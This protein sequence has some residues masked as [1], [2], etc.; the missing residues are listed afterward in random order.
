[1]I[2]LPALF[3]TFFL[4]L[5]FFLSEPSSA[6]AQ[7]A[8]LTRMAPL[9]QKYCVECHG[10][11]KAEAGIALDSYENQADAVEDGETW[12]KVLDA[13]EARAMPPID[14]PQP[15]LD[16]LESIVQ[17]I[18]KDY[19]AAQ[20][21]KRSGTAPVVIRRLNRQEYDNTLRDLTGLDLKLAESFPMDEIGF[22]FDNVGSALNISPV[23]I[24]KYL[25]AAEQALDAA[26]SAPDAEPMA[27]IELIGLNT[28]PLRR[29]EPVT[30]A[31]TLK[32]GEYIVDFSLVRVGISE[33]APTPRLIVSFGSDTRAIEALRVQ[34]ET[35]VYR[36]WM[37][38]GQGDKQVKVE[39]PEQAKL[40]VANAPGVEIADNVSGDQRYGSDRGLHVDSM[41]VKG[42]VVRDFASLPESH[43]RLL[44]KKPGFGDAAR[45]GQGQEV[46]RRFMDRAFR[47]PATDEEIKRVMAIF[48]TANDHGESYEKAVQIALTSV[49]VSPQFLYLVEP[50]TD[51][52]NE[53]LDEFELASRL[54]YFLWS[55]MP[56]EALFSEARAGTLRK[57]LRTQ[58]DR[59]ID[60]PKSIAL[61]ENFTGQWL[62]LRKLTGVSPDPDLFA[63]FDDELKSAMRGETEQ[64][65]AHILKNNRNVLDLIDSD[66]TF[67]NEPLARHYGIEGVNGKEFRQV[68]LADRRRGGVLTQGSVLTLTSN[69]N[70]T[71]P[72]KRG[73]WILQ[74]ILGTPPPPPPPEVEKLDESPQS[75]AAASLRD[76][77]EAHRSAAACASCHKQ[78]DP[79]GFALENYDPVGRWRASDG[80]FPV[81]PSGELA[82]G[83][84]FGEIGELKQIL[85][86]KA[87][88]KFSRCLIEYMLTY[89]LGRGLEPFD[90]CT[91]E[92]V[93]NRLESDEFRIRNIVYGIV[94]SDAFQYRGVSEQGGR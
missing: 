20:C 75:A 14:K 39:L 7:D 30:F 73:Q 57:N 1:V 35:V 65:F 92:E 8:F 90:Y 88:K 85:K 24:E 58:V 25:D 43:R 28:Y 37:S 31:H 55:S 86:T 91:I 5:A 64:F 45:F 50:G 33:T 34:D 44:G 77:L 10:E 89:A 18:E 40:P 21:E 82:G 87:S 11:N 2:K 12:M 71:S 19:L 29:G 4:A 61:V 22:G 78:M 52:K 42:P 93:R 9:F 36:F 41:V 13:I 67:L 66:Y 53:R 16:E 94:E 32:P 26:I 27:P 56:D 83:L 6:H 48:T 69:P 46:V 84:S 15:T 68:A 81:D 72:V 60:D 62:Q 79:L 49:L 3:S 70:R 74:Q 51:S 17:W 23:H 38:V 59:M 76:R 47:R 80:P 54:S 63:S